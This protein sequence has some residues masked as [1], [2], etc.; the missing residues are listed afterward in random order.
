ML[1]NWN[2][3]VQSES[4]SDSSEGSDVDRFTSRTADSRHRFAQ[5]RSFSLK[6]RLPIHATVPIPP[7]LHNT[8]GLNIQLNSSEMFGGKPNSY[9][10][11]HD[12]ESS[13]DVSSPR[14]NNSPMVSKINVL[15]YIL[16]R[17]R[18]LCIH[19]N[20]NYLFMLFVTY[21]YNIFN[22]CRFTKVERCWPR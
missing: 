4:N 5:K 9:S 17:R 10:I 3:T 7:E 21:E 14:D 11:M 22:V 13:L 15:N 20:G 6:K 12:D 16:F 8:H 18:N 2:I 19:S 1:I